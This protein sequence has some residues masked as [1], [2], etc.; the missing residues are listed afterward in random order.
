[1]SLTRNMNIKVAIE[2]YY[3]FSKYGNLDTSNF[4]LTRSILFEEKSVQNFRTFTIV[5]KYLVWIQT[6]LHNFIHVSNV[7]LIICVG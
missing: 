6:L 5:T 3:I 4:S 7:C 2:L 1:M